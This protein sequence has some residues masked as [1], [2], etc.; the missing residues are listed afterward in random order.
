MPVVELRDIDKSFTGVHALNNIN[1]DVA[2]GE[3]HALLRR[4]W[5]RKV[6]ADQGAIRSVSPK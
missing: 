3:V 4:K 2:P 5:R 1:F 6:D